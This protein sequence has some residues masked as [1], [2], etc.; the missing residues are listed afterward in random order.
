MGA[1]VL[2]LHPYISMVDGQLKAK[3]KYAGNMTRCLTSYVRDLSAEY[4]SYDKT[5]CF[6]THT[7]SDQALV[8][9]VISLTKELFEFDEI[10]ESVAGS[11]VS[12][13]CGPNTIGLLFINE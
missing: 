8:D 7:I 2:K 1:K 12:A 13:H 4:H 3:K 6:I 5:R 11:T 9:L 10:Y